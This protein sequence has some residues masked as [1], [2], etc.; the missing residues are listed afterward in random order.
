MQAREMV[1]FGGMLATGH[2]SSELWTLNWDTWQWSLLSGTPSGTNNCACMGAHVRC[3]KSQPRRRQAP[4]LHTHRTEPCLYGGACCGGF[5][6]MAAG[7][8]PCARVGHAMCVAPAGYGTVGLDDGDRTLLI[9]GGGDGTRGFGDL[10][11]L[12]LPREGAP[13]LEGQSVRVAT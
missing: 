5:D 2:A 10:S 11:S 13:L 7:K 9:F 8:A 1:V 12:T 3:S 4:C 6:G